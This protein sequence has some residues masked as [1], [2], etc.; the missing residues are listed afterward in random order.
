MPVCGTA[1]GNRLTARDDED[2]V[3]DIRQYNVYTVDDQVHTVQYNAV[4]SR[5]QPFTPRAPPRSRS[6]G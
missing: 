6:R 2:D 5:I 3:S 4:L 1:T